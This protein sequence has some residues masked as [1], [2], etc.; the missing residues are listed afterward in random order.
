MLEGKAVRVRR[1]STASTPVAVA[2][3]QAGLRLR[4]PRKDSCCG[5]CLLCTAH[6]FREIPWKCTGHCEPIEWL[7]TRDGLAH[8]LH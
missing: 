2:S 8:S 7:R 1:T 5:L 4:V 3:Y 6:A